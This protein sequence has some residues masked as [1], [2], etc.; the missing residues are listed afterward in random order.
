MQLVS[1]TIL[2]IASPLTDMVQLLS[3]AQHWGKAYSHIN[4]LFFSMAA[5]LI[6]EPL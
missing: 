6:Q 5:E 4:L 1:L 3:V 2:D